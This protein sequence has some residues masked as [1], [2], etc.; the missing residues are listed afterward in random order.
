ME[1]GALFTDLYQLN[2]ASSYLRRGMTDQATFSLFVRKL[3][4]H[5]GFLVAAGVGDCLAY[6]ED[7]RFDDAELSY[8]RDVVGFDDATV[9][10]F[11]ALRFTGGARAVP[12]GRVVLPDEPLLE[13]TAPIAEAQLVETFLLNRV[14]FQTAIATKA[15][16]CV[17]A[18]R[19]ADCVDFATRRTHGIDAAFAVARLTAIAGFAATSNVAAAQRY[20]L[21]AS[22][23]MAHS[24]IEAFDSERE[25]FLAFAADV[26]GP[27]T[28]LVD[29]YDTPR[30]V[31]TA[32]EVIEQLGLSGRLAVRLDSG[33]LLAL[34]KQ[35]RRTLDD[36]GH[37]EVRIFASGGLD[38]HQIEELLAG[39]APIDGFGIGTQ[40][41]V[42]GDAPSLDS[43]YKLVEYAGRPVL[44]LSPGKETLPGTKQVFR[45]LDGSGDVIA[46]A[47][48]PV[49]D[50]SEPL[51]A[52]MMRDGRRVGP[53]DPL[54]AARAR[55][56]ADLAALPAEATKLRD[57]QPPP[58]RLSAALTQ[59]RDEVTAATRR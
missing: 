49:P 2:M 33:D 1:P 54:D 52:E 23:T 42:S 37:P 38:E 8:L 47:D 39:G 31:E 21:V 3:P 12:E 18:A 55:C 17:I 6:L 11:A 13:V 34:A 53:P 56:R 36:A 24:Y 43:A 28:F 51:L 30:G 25:A 40:L 29:T 59:L 35:A 32:I 26:A 44:K 27:V 9:A 50:G 5:R 48:E 45:R 57:P 46:C 58:V 10:A 14:T 4:P 16:R 22:G 7:F 15:A 19:D 41:G 20:G